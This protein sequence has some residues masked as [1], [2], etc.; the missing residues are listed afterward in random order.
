MTALA[1][2]GG[3]G[4]T[5]LDGVRIDSALTLATPYGESAAGIGG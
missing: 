3:A 4:L 2:I 5:Q 1:I